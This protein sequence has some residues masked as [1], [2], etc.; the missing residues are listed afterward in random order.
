[1]RLHTRKADGVQGGVRIIVRPRGSWQSKVAIENGNQARGWLYV[2]SQERAMGMVAAKGLAEWNAGM[3]GYYGVMVDCNGD[4]ALRCCGPQ[5]SFPYL[6]AKL[7][8]ELRETWE[9]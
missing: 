1:M 3:Y 9:R 5:S 6:N 8:S 2:S 4:C 7:D